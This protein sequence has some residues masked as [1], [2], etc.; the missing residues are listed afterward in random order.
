M[1]EGTPVEEVAQRMIAVLPGHGLYATAPSWD[2]HWL[3]RLLRAAGL[4]RHAL[5]LQD[6]DQA[7]R[8]A[9]VEILRVANIAPDLHDRIFQGIL[10]NARRVDNNLGPP[11]HRALADARREQRVWHDVH[12]IAEEAAARF[13][14]QAT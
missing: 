10:A 12:R 3:S 4:P 14:R 13:L 11:T 1:E 8:E 7:H 9:A 6:S 2:G 5:R